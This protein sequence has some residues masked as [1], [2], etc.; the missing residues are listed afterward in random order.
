M[1][2]REETSAKKLRGGY[3]TP[4]ALAY[5]VVAM[6][7]RLLGPGSVKAILEPSA[8]DGAFLPAIKDGIKGATVTAVEIDCAEAARFANRAH[9]AHV[10]A[11]VHPMS[12][13]EFA[14]LWDRS[15]DLVLGNP[16]FVRYQFVSAADQSRII[17][18][19]PEAAGGGVSN[20]WIPITIAALRK[21]RHGGAFGLVLPQELLCTKSGGAFRRFVLTHFE[22]VTI[23]FPERGAFGGILQDVVL[24]A[25]RKTAVSASLRKV[26]FHARETWQHL[27]PANGDTW[28]PFLL[29]GT[30][31]AAYHAAV[32][33]PGV[34]KLGELARLAVATVTGANAYFSLTDPTRSQYHL[35]DATLP[36]L[37]RLGD[38]T[39][40]FFDQSDHESLQR[41]GRPS[42]ML[43]A[44]PQLFDHHEG[45]RAYVER[46]EQEGL[47]ERYKCRIRTP[48]YE[49]PIVAPKQLMVSKRGYLH[50]RMV[51]NSACVTTTDTIYQGNV[52]G[53]VDPTILA[54]SFHTSL[55]ALSAEIEGRSYGGGVLELV[56]S[57][58]A[59]VLVWLWSKAS[60][61][62][63]LDKHSRDVGGQKDRDASLVYY[64]D[65]LASDS[66]PGY[67]ELLGDLQQGWCRL[68]E[69]RR[70][71]VG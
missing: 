39:G 3:Y 31:L 24:V 34:K 45:L 25:G 66:S 13:L 2:H 30:Q 23:A 35:E 33:L 14:E 15:Y 65:R 4:E 20:L 68:R 71:G 64:S 37:P 48:W 8:G 1:I 57:E 6:A 41:K 26:T 9:D 69:F 59:R 53:D 32:A 42:W 5:Q 36:L 27:I 54:S 18:V 29:N 47:H 46:G 67:G 61:V 44:K 22:D 43:A 62:A 17:D 10:R 11:I 60:D 55:T 28:T 52:I 50:P 21:L 56:P 12:F 63:V 38:A 51:V 7:K 58:L 49:V 40:L 16:P 19:A 70:V